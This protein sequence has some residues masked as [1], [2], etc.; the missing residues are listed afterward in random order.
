MAEDKNYPRPIPYGP[1][2]LPWDKQV[3]EGAK[4]AAPLED[5][6]SV[7]EPV[8]PSYVV[9]EFPKI[10]YKMFEI[11][12]KGLTD[13]QRAEALDALKLYADVQHL[14]FMGFQVNQDQSYSSR[15]SWLL[16]MHTNNVGDPFASGQVTLNSKFCERAVLDYFAALWNIDWPHNYHK[17]CDTSADRY[18]GYVLTMGCTEAN[19]YGLFN[20]RDYLR[21][22]KLIVD[23]DKET[24]NDNLLTRGK[25]A[26]SKRLMYVSPQP[27]EEN[28][29]AYKPIVFYSED[30]HYSVVKAV[31]MLDLT[32]FSQEG[33]DH[34]DGE[35]PIT[36][37]G[38]WPEEV[39]SYKYETDNPLSGAIIVKDLKKLVR[40]FLKKGY[41]ILIVL[42]VGTTWKGAYDDVPAVND[43]LMD[44]GKEFPWLWDREVKYDPD[45]PDIPPDHRRGFWVHVDG[46]LGAPF[47]PFIEMAYN[48]GKIDKKGPCFDFRNESVMSIGCSMHKWIGG[49]WPS[50]IY[51]TR[52]KYVLDLPTPEYIG[53]PD[54]T[55]GGSR[56]GFSPVIFWDYLS[57][58][59][60]EDNMEKALDTL[61]VAAYLEK[62]LRKLEAK[63]QK[64]FCLDVDLWIARS[65]LALT[66][67]FRRVNPIISYK[68]TIDGEKLV[69]P[70]SK[71]KEERYYS[72][73]FVMHPVDKERVDEFINDLREASQ[74]DWTNAFPD[75]FIDDHGVS[76]HNPHTVASNGPPKRAKCNYIMFVPHEGRGFG[77]VIQP[78][79][80][81]ESK[82]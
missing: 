31:R 48:L 35:C 71:G 41:P 24:K 77:T 37:D 15:L 16:D 3:P 18:W 17:A 11:P 19:I 30:T 76:H 58:M 44:L 40:F 20:A 79:K 78:S 25:E 67:R 73:V 81:E 43:M 65:Q 5:P 7:Y 45:D 9:G 56:S 55:F 36:K 21:G 8:P 38:T 46:A 54:T 39:P 69:V 22:R 74:D 42:N 60:Y 70:T 53:S 1:S 13:I 59:S 57:R 33:S 61:N 64:K 62:E 12:P 23:P 51:M 47:L 82:I 27:D 32:T 26:P 10:D 75:E 63:L 50:G 66:V 28:E 6:I 4:V 34:F 52:T 72:H 29:N 2:Q 68:W 49:P 14:R 80:Q